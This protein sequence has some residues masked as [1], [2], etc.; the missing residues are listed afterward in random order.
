MDEEARN[1][2]SIT[3][4]DTLARLNLGIVVLLSAVLA[5]TTRCALGANSWLCFHVSILNL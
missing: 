4:S 1:I 2:A 3:I 5:L